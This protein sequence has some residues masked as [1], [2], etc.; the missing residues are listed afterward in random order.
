MC[1]IYG[2]IAGPNPKFKGRLLKKSLLALAKLSESR[3]KDSSGLCTL[4]L[5]D[6]SFDIIKGPI[7]VT[8]LLK[9]QSVIEKL[10]ALFGSYFQDATRMAFGHARLVTNG[11]QLNHVNNQPV[12]KDDII[13]VH[14]GIVVNVNELWQNCNGISSREYEIDTEIIPSLVRFEIKHG[15]SPR[16]SVVKTLQRIEGTASIALTF[17]DLNKFILATNNGSLYILTNSKDILY[18]ASERSMLE[19]LLRKSLK[20]FTSDDFCIEQIQSNYILD[21]DLDSFDI[22][23]S[24]FSEIFDE[25]IKLNSLQSKRKIITYF[26]DSTSAQLS[27]V[28]DL[29]RMHLEPEASVEKELLIYPKSDI[30]KLKRCSKCILPETFPFIEFDEKGLC[31]YCKNYKRVGARKSLNELKA[32]VEP[33]RSK[34]GSPDCFIP[35]SGGRDSTYVVHFLK[36]EL[37]LNVVTYTYDWGL[38]TDLARRNIARVCGRLGVEN[39]IIAADIHW[40]REN[41]RKNITAWL[42]NPELG[43]IPL[44]MAGDKYFFYHAY[45]VK[46]QLDIDLEIWGVNDLENTDFKTGFAGLKPQYDKKR[47]YSISVMNKIK[48]FSFFV[49]NMCSSPGYINQSLLDSLGSFASR[50]FTPKSHYY[51]LFDYI[52]WDEKQIEHV[53]RTEYDWESSVDTNSTWRIGDGTASFYNYIYTLTSGF[54]ENDTFRSNQIRQGMISREEGLKLV[55]EENEPRYNS[56]KWY[57]EILGLEYISTIQKI[58]A[59]PRKF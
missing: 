30:R 39:I 35:F 46:K 34:D 20:S 10:D 47:I 19:K 42:K 36:K 54:S 31:N 29:N 58:N 49:K 21:I 15:Y 57:L 14:N 25:K 26:E 32:I 41:V 2:V 37:G 56:L 11:T 44:F 55:Y 8:Q 18:F 17:T 22:N 24:H 5:F 59:I 4:N 40:K 51:H 3:G 33:Y 28:L 53:I 12:I 43:M 6:N 1:G 23:I 52:N 50:Y 16:Q 7:S 38:V 48:L 45:K 9:R 27:T 13:C